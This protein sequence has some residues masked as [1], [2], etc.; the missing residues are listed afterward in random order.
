MTWGFGHRNGPKHSAHAIIHHSAL[1]TC[2]LAGNFP[3]KGLP[4][5]TPESS[6]SAYLKIVY[7]DDD[8]GCFAHS[9]HALVCLDQVEMNTR[10]DDPATGG[11]V[12]GIAT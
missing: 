3:P 4:A 6:L 7:W 8:V 2:K 1:Q 10:C 5:P 11:K 12:L 9:F